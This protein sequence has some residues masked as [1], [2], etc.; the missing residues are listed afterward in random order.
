[1]LWPFLFMKLLFQIGFLFLLIQGCTKSELAQP[2]EYDGPQSEAENVE[3]FYSEN[4]LI[5]VKLL[6]D[7]VYEFEG[8]DREFPK[9]IYLEFFDEEG[10]LSSRLRANHA[11]YT[12]KENLWK[13]TGKV[14]VENIVKKEQ[15]NTEE[16]FWTPTK[17]EIYTESFVTIRMAAE[18]IYGEGLEAKQ[19]MSTYTIKKPQGEFTLA[20]SPNEG[21]R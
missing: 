16:L 17:K 4:Q 18:V 15:L 19:D 3:L 8:G 2:L 10:N 12:K 20:D 14:E 9:G 13:A 7:L 6:A 5:K 21:T 11:F 1:M